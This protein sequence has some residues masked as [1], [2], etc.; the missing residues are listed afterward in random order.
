MLPMSF[1]KLQRLVRLFA[2]RVRL[3]DGLALGNMR[4]LQELVAINFTPEVIE[5]IG[6][7]KD[8]RV[9]R[10]IVNYPDMVDGTWNFWERFLMSL[11]RCTNLQDLYM[12]TNL[13][14]ECSLDCMQYVPS[15][16]Q[17]FMSSHILMTA[18]PRWINST[19]LS[20]LTT[21][22]IQLSSDADLLPHHLEKLAELP[23]LRFL[24]LW[25]GGIWKLQKFSIP[26]CACAFRCLRH[27]YFH[28]SWM[29]LT[30]QPGALPELQR[31]C[32]CFDP[33]L[34]RNN[35]NDFGLKNIHSLRHV[36]IKFLSV[37]PENRQE[38]E[39]EVREA[40]KDNPNHPSLELLFL[41]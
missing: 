3:P 10:I 39:A 41:G 15:G 25:S 28:S 7:L 33:R 26:S 5:E 34:E 19:T 1:V 27:F 36:V 11:E 16:L 38:V 8:L 4:S 6:D 32:L 31:L 23:S 30:F 18:F 40:L 24:R 2:N 20:S 29:F 35:L 17:R 22:S 21:L 9:L 14:T 37:E 12:E 13:P